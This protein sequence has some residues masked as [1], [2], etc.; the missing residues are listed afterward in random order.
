M[1]TN[2]NNQITYLE[3]TE[4][5]LLVY[6]KAHQIMM[7]NEFVRLFDYTT[8]SEY[9]NILTNDDIDILVK[10]LIRVEDDDYALDGGGSLTEYILQNY[11]WRV[12]GV[13]CENLYTLADLAAI[14][15]GWFVY[16]FE[17]G[18]LIDQCKTDK[19]TK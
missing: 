19:E 15:N 7:H 13:C 5:E 4:D 10:M 17:W 2:N 12:K 18:D 16:D 1:E 8:Y 6:N 9:K 14:D 3:Y 11:L